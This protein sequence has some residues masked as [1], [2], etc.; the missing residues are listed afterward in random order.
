MFKYEFVI[1]GY[2]NQGCN[3]KIN[4]IGDFRN[5]T[6]F[7]LKESKNYID[8]LF[9]KG[10]VRVIVNVNDF[11]DK[12]SIYDFINGKFLDKFEE[13]GFTTRNAEDFNKEQFLN[14]LKKIHTSFINF[15]DDWSDLFKNSTIVCDKMKAI[16]NLLFDLINYDLVNFMGSDI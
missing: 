1:T 5:V 7:R 11:R 10:F 6:G 15:E 2:E 13:L 9:D 8:D 3:R 14:K 12:F 4:A 16:E